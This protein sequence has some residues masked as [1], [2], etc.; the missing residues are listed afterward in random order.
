MSGW[1][2]VA[3]QYGTRCLGVAWGS[4]LGIWH[5]SLLLTVHGIQEN[6]DSIGVFVNMRSANGALEANVPFPVSQLKDI[7]P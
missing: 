2:N 3:V 6:W 5:R 4:L 1:Q 7:D